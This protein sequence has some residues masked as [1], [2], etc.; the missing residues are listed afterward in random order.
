[1]KPSHLFR[2]VLPEASLMHDGRFGR[3]VST[4]RE[5]SDA[6]CGEKLLADTH[7]ENSDEI[8]PELCGGARAQADTRARTKGSARNARVQYLRACAAT[9]ACHLGAWC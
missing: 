1:M 4:L 8:A 3:Q 9:P 6:A 5:K 2:S 7:Q